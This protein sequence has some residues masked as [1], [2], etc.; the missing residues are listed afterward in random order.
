MIQEVNKFHLL[1]ICCEVKQDSIGEIHLK[2]GNLNDQMM[3]KLGNNFRNSRL[4]NFPKKGSRI[5]LYMSN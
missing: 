5:N 1:D 3:K 4:P 2:V